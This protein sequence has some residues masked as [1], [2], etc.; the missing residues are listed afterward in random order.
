MDQQSLAGEVAR[1]LIAVGARDLP[2]ASRFWIVK[3]ITEHGVFD[4]F[5][6]ERSPRGVEVDDP[7]PTMIAGAA[8]VLVQASRRLDPRAQ[9]LEAVGTAVPLYQLPF[10]DASKKYLELRGDWL[11]LDTLAGSGGVA[12]YPDLA[13]DVAEWTQFRTDWE[14][15]NIDNSDIGGRLNA[16]VVR[17]NR[18][19]A[20][21]LEHQS[22]KTVFVQDV[23]GNTQNIDPADATPGW[24]QAKAVDDWA[25]KSPFLNALTNPSDRARGIKLP[26]IPKLPG[27]IPGGLAI[28]V[29]VLL[30][31]NQ[32]LGAVV[33]K[34]VGA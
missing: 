33:R 12:Q 17:V 28:I 24:D 8:R 22:G 29:G 34:V 32:V 2:Q 26:G 30:V 25:K 3:R 10:S 1:A 9:P 20:T 14:A 27:G 23:P 13:T 11:A 18:V 7:T 15:G 21:V 6:R 31:G 5:T 19:R 4:L 16:E